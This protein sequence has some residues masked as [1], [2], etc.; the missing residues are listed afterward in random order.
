MMDTYEIQSDVSS[1][2][3]EKTV[4]IPC[5]S[6]VVIILHQIKLASGQFRKKKEVKQKGCW[7]VK[8]SEAGCG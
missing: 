7:A 2:R 1:G 6:S 3:D 8:L 5:F 4:N